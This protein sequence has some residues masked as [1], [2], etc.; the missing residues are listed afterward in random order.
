[1]IEF[2]VVIPKFGHRFGRNENRRSVKAQ[3]RG[4]IQVL[5][6]IKSPAKLRMTSRA[7]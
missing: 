4:G 5:V 1:M 3:V 6:S 7:S 2:H